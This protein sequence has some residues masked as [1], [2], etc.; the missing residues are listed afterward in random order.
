MK[1][2]LKIY[3]AVFFFLTVSSC[4]IVSI[5]V[6]EKYD[7]DG[8]LEQVTSI[9]KYGITDW[10]EVDTQSLILQKGPGEYYL[11]VLKIPAPELPF[12]NRIKLTSTGDMIRAG[13]DD[14]ILYNLSHIRQSYPIDRIYRFKD[15][16]QM[17][18]FRD[19]LEGNRDTGQND[20][21]TVSPAKSGLPRKNGV[22]I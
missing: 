12:L 15:S 13:M 22:E 7:L 1:T 19:R 10:E 14:V 16:E 18:T 11:L 20:D 6:P 8:E 21:N 17:R 2:F 5:Q 9:F 4:A 3:T